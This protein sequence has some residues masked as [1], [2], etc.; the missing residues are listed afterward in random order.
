MDCIVWLNDQ[1][2]TPNFH[3]FL[4]SL[5]VLHDGGVGSW[6]CRKDAKGVT[7]HRTGR[8]PGIAK[9]IHPLPEAMDM[10]NASGDIEEKRFKFCMEKQGVD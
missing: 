1:Y 7:E 2:G 9:P 8:R 3:I 5:F 6:I 4:M 10:I